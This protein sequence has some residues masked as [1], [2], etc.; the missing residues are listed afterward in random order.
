M[1]DDPEQRL[2]SWP[3]ID[4]IAEAPARL[5]ASA[6][7]LVALIK[8][9]PQMTMT[10]SQIIAK[11]KIKDEAL[12]EIVEHIPV[13]FT[14]DR[15][16]S[17]IRL[18]IEAP[19]PW[20]LS[21]AQLADIERTKQKQRDLEA[22]RLKTAEQDDRDTPFNNLRRRLEG[23]GLDTKKAKSFLNMIW[24][25]QTPERI[26]AALDLADAKKPL[27][28]PEGFLINVLKS[29]SAG[30][31]MSAR[32]PLTVF[33][34]QRPND[35][36]KTVF[37]GWEDQDQNGHRYKLYRRPDG[38][39]VREKPLPDEPIPSYSADVGYKVLS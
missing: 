33:M 23:L 17:R 14:Y 1:F 16:T 4:Q 32:R 26:S 36:G 37:V 11:T 31:A 19:D 18:R 9:E 35:S 3:A 30:P 24:R 22:Q 15:G 8:S 20:D 2:L 21:P 29:G 27:D 13:V 39:L 5:I 25:Q 28:K 34:Q 12:H 38:R 6:M 7:R 10:V